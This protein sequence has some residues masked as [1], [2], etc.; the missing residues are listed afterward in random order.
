MNHH[1]RPKTGHPGP[2]TRDT[3]EFRSRKLNPI[4]LI[5][6]THD[7]E[8]GAKNRLSPFSGI[9]FWYV[10]H[11]KLGLVS[12]G[13]RFRRQSERFRV[14]IPMDVIPMDAIPSVT[15]TWLKWSF[16]IYSISSHV[17]YTISAIIIAAALANSSSSTSLSAI[18]I[19][20]AR[21]FHSRRKWYEEQSPENGVDLWRR[22]QALRGRVSCMGISRSRS[23]TWRDW[24]GAHGLLHQQQF[25]DHQQTSYTKHMLLVSTSRKTLVSINCMMHLGLC[26]NG[27]SAKSPSAH[28]KPIT[29]R[30][31]L[32][33]IFNGNVAIYIYWRHNDVIVMKFTSG[34]QN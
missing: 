9:G 29:E 27:L 17:W 14:T 24:F 4:F 16:M 13:T 11:A 12:A 23:C 10:C 5:L 28:R 7:P 33:N 26:V 15:C 34:I 18:F 20:G 30:C 21:N 22:F 3:N 25:L 8:T 32:C 31:S 1:Q 19:F 6:M 2:D